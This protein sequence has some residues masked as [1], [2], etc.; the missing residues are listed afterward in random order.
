MGNSGAR[1]MELQ[2]KHISVVG[3]AASGIA[4]AL[5]LRRHGARV[6]ISELRPAEQLRAEI[7]RL[8]EA[9]VAIETG[10]HRERTFLSADWIVVSP[11]VPSD[12]PV[13]ARARREGIPVMGEIELAARFLRAPLI[14]ITGSN[15]KTTT[16]ALTGHLLTALGLKNQVG[17]NIGTPLISLVE[18]AGPDEWA[19]AEVSSFQL[20]T[21]ERFHARIAAVLNLS[22]DH[23]DR[24]GSMEAYAAAKQNVFLNQ[25]PA[26]F[27][28][29]N[30]ADEYCRRFA[31][32]LEARGASQVRWFDAQGRLPAGGQG[33]TATE[34]RI[35]WREEAGAGGVTD[36][37]LLRLA[38]IPLRGA[39]NVE[40]VLAACAMVCLAAQVSAGAAG[41]PEAISRAG[42]SPQTAAGIAAGVASFK[43]VEHRLEFVAKLGGVEYFNDS[44]AT[45]VD[46]TLKAIE[47]FPGGLW[48]ILGGKDKG[49]DYDA[50]LAPLQQRARAALLIG[51]AAAKIAR[52]LA[53]LGD[54]LIPAGTLERALEIAAARAQPGDTI[55]LAP[56]CSSF[57]QFDNYQHRGRAFKEWVGRRAVAAGA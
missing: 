51:A 31:A 48:V 4:T 3:M 5:F 16:T 55:L 23:L 38:E 25:S 32:S 2:G 45:N 22:P 49:G 44:K 57:D 39:H 43:A 28:V 42:I 9:G 37:V 33:A 52:Q 29:L 11:G 19:V 8:L 10:G 30:A 12:L 18:A 46:A 36:T 34:G 21:A 13:L 41:H 6:V 26:D 1:R 20:E 40:N 47:S 50:L 17:G 53:P 14:A 27:A 56:A 54:R 24:H 15:G 35:V 7:P